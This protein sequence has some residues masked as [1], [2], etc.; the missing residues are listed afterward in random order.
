MGTSDVRAEVKKALDELPDERLTIALE[1]LNGLRNQEPLARTYMTAVYP[2]LQALS[3][4]DRAEFLTELLYATKQ[5]SLSGNWGLLEEVIDAWQETA[6]ILADADLVARLQE[7]QAEIQQGKANP[8][9]E[10]KQRLHI[11]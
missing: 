5:A 2:W 1:L 8:W 6:A 4:A 9:N 7:A 10:V 3:E 11:S